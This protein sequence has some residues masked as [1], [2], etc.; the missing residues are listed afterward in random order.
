[1]KQLL[2][3]CILMLLCGCSCS[4]MN[5][6]SQMTPTPS[7]TPTP[8][9]TEDTNLQPGLS[10]YNGQD[11]LDYL[12]NNYTLQNSSKIDQLD[13]N[14]IEGYTFTMN[15]DHFY[16]LRFDRSNSN[17]NQW[18]NEA[19]NNGSIEVKVG[20]EMKKFYAIVN[21]DYMLL[22]ETENLDSGFREHFQNFNLSQPSSTSTPN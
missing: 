16:L 9:T 13:G 10:A 3:F 8:N 14:A 17:A 11:Y 22:Y 7:S 1:M 2:I 5:N 19:M 20:N 6:N 18:I 12:G 4:T 15:N 21:Q